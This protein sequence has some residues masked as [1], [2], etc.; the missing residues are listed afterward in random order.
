MKGK[1]N[2]KKQLNKTKKGGMGCSRKQGNKYKY[3]SNTKRK[4]RR[5]SNSRRMRNST[6]NSISNNRRIMRGGS[7]SCSDFNANKELLNNTILGCKMW[8]G[9][10]T[11]TWGNTGQYYGLESHFDR[12]DKSFNI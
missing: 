10:D 9:G 7:N 6:R 8:D 5:I 11:S 3:R 4:S 2:K 12:F 1:Y